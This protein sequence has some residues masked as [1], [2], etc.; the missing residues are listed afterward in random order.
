MDARRIL[1]AV[2]GLFLVVGA[3][4]AMGAIIDSK[5]SQRPKP[6][7]VLKTV[8]VETVTNADVDLVV[9]AN[10][11][12]VAK[13]RVELFAEVQ[14]VF[15]KGSKLF[16]T[17]QAYTAGQRLITIDA[18][19]YYANVQ[20][21]KSD[22]YN[23][24]TSILPDLRLDFPEVYEKWQQ[25][26]MQFDIEK[27]TL[28]LPAF[29]SDKEKFFITGKGVVSSYYNVKNL[30]QRLSKYSISAPFTGILAEALVTEGTLVRAGQKLGEFIKPGTYE[31]QVALPKSYSEFLQVGKTVQLANLDKTKIYNGVV[32]R[33]NG[34]VDLASQTV[35]TFIEVK[36]DDLK[37]GQYLE[38]QLNAK[39]E[40]NAIE[41]DR[42][43]LLENNQLFVLQDSVLATIDVQPVYFSD[44]KV[45][46]KNVPDGTQLIAKPITG[47]YAGM[48]V[49]V[50][51]DKTSAAE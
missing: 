48:L 30:E 16:K 21:A 7:K 42:A 23:L 19:E 26:V 46:V 50:F 51:N 38:A 31:L 49:K 43:L 11:N 36:G 18:A 29:S 4:F 39:K 35:T 24:L 32:S 10:G 37:E 6:Q 25:Y 15:K 20:S 40:P 13:E 9:P 33:V 44:K 17:G 1:L 5:K 8:F 34:R 12:L 45:V 28:K 22:F 47:G 41:I 3:Y 27:S 14:G 2:F